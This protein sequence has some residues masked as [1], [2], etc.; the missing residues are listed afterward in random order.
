MIN[1][2]ARNASRPAR[3]RDG[4]GALWKT[5]IRPPMP[6]AIPVVW[7]SIRLAMVAPAMM[8]ASVNQIRG[9]GRWVTL[10]RK[11]EPIAR[12]KDMKAYVRS[13]LNL[14]E[15]FFTFR[16]PGFVGMCIESKATGSKKEVFPAWLESF[17]KDSRSNDE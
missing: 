4:S 9:S 10:K 17:F 12:E 15:P 3:G 14:Y 7:I 2:D 13:I 1:R 6:I 16:S 5:K 11:A 8:Q